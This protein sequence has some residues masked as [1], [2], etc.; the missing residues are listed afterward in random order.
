MVRNASNL[1]VDLTNIL[2]YFQEMSR[3]W[4]LFWLFWHKIEINYFK[5]EET[6]DNTFF[7]LSFM[8]KVRHSFALKL[9]YQF[10][11]C[12]PGRSAGISNIRFDDL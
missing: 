8:R 1:Q 11:V 5:L 3:F 7:K 2:A 6:T 4:V 12:F 10:A 9:Q